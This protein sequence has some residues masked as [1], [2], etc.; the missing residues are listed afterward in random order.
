MEDKSAG[1]RGLEE[2]PEILH[3][4]KHLRLLRRNGWEFVERSKTN[5]AVVIVAVTTEG[6]LVL[7]EQFREPVNSQVVELPAGLVGD[8]ESSEG[9]EVAALRELQEETGY[10]A[11]SV[12]ILA[13]GPPSVGLS[14]ETVTFV[15]ASGLTKAGQGGGVGHERIVVHLVPLAG[16][17]AWL[18][19]KESEGARVDPKIYA[20]LFFAGS[21]TGM[22]R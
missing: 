13:T 22:L 4:G 20:G 9:I 3:D 17:L 12:S 8:V 16:T 10:A 7:V 15:K 5:V 2:D 11:A 18:R 1:R 6:N 14:S 19:T 21:G